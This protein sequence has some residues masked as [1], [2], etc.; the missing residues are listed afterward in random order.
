[1]IYRS[2]ASGRLL[3]LEE[4]RFAIAGDGRLNTTASDTV[5]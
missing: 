5:Y 3:Q 1:M 2:I 4:R